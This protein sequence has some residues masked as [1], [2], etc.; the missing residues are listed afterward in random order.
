MVKPLPK[1]KFVVIVHFDTQPMGF[2]INS[3]VSNW[4]RKRP[5]LLA[6]EASISS[7]EHPALDHDSFVDCRDLYS[8]HHWDLNDRDPVSEQAKTN[9]LEAIRVCPTIKRKYKQAI[10]NR[11]GVSGL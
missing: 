3:R 9:I 7:S 4:L 5:K 1:D 11:E 8:F 10:L 2:L 6:C